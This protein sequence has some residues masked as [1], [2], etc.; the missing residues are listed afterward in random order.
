VAAVAIWFSHPALFI[1]TAGGVVLLIEVIHHKKWSTLVFFCCGAIIA[2]ISFG[3]NYMLS[4]APL[5][6]TTVLVD[7]WYKSFAPFPIASLQ[8]AYWYLYVFLRMFVFPVGLSHYELLLGVIAFACGIISLHRGNQNISIMFMLSILITLFASALHLYPFE[9]RLLLFLTPTIVLLI[10]QGVAS[11]QSKLSTSSPLIST[12]F[13]VLL[14]AHPVM[15][16]GYHVVK[17]RAPEELRTVLTYVDENYRDGDVIYVYYAS[18]NAY[19]YYAYRYEFSHEYVIG[20]ESRNDWKQYYY[21][22]ATMKGRNRVWVLV[23]HIATWHGVDE[24]KLF[25]SYLGMLGKQKDVLR[26]S[27][28]AAYLYDLSD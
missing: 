18:L 6:R 7:T 22:L 28:A 12:I 16:A 24:E 10:A 1:F 15:R 9:G 5:T 23:S 8:D 19:R 2:V 21:D 14:L 26:V 20:I 25:V 4:L 3:A 13:I 11:I 17:P 27:G